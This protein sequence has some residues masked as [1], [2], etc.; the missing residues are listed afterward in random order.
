MQKSQ[1]LISGCKKLRSKEIWKKNSNLL[2]KGQSTLLQF[3][4]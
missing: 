4:V 1:V 3:A 2:G